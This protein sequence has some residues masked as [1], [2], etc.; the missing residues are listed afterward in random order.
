VVNELFCVV[1]MQGL[2][3]LDSI[4]FVIRSAE[5][6]SPDILCCYLVQRMNET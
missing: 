4:E 2:M 6:I 5:K 1:N 3:L